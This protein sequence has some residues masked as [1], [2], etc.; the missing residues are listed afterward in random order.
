MVSVRHWNA[1]QFD[2][3]AAL[4]IKRTVRSDVPA[5]RAKLS[6][7]LARLEETVRGFG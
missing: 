7:L 1:R 6:W 2:L 5:A 3:Y 4:G